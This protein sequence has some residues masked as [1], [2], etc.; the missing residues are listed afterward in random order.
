[1]Q[2]AVDEEEYQNYRRAAKQHWD[3]MKQYYENVR[4]SKM[5]F[6]CLRSAEKCR[7]LMLL[8]RV[9][10]KKSIVLYMKKTE[11]RNELCLDLRTQDAANVSNLLRLHLKQLANIPSFE[12]L[13]VIIGVDDGSFKM[14]QRRRKVMKYLEKNSIQWTEDEPHSGN[15]LIRINQVENRQLSVDVQWRDTN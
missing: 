14:G 13:K 8:G 11:S 2:P 3:M 10:R 6:I 15:L 4:G 5:M 7:L 12:Y 9:T 1:M